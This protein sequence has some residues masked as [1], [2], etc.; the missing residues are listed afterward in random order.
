VEALIETARA[1]PPDTRAS[2]SLWQ[3]IGVAAGL[4]W[5]PPLL[6]L[7]PHSPLRLSDG[8]RLAL[9]VCAVA[10]AL[11]YFQQTDLLLLYVLPV[12]ALPALVGSLGFPLFA[13]AG[14]TGLKAL[15]IIPAA[16]YAWALGV[17]WR[18]DEAD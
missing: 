9:V 18:S 13:A 10:L 12:G 2:L 7:M 16:V 3:Y 4:L 5:L 15:A 17:G 1:L 14:W 6:A 11:P 8:R